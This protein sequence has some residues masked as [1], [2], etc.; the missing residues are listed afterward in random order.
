MH[1]YYDRHWISAAI[2]LVGLFVFGYF[3]E[4]LRGL[5]GND[6]LLLG[7]AFIFLFCLGRLG[8]YVAGK[9]SKSKSRPQ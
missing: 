1:D 4:S 2:A 9:I 5:L 6:Y 8:N 3:Y 7:V